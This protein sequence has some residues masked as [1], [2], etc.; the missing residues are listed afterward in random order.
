MCG[1]DNDNC[2]LH[3]S[4]Q[5]VAKSLVSRISGPHSDVAFLV[6]RLFCLFLTQ[7]DDTH[8]V[9]S[10]FLIPHIPH[11]S[12]MPCIV[13]V[14][15]GG[16]NPCQMSLWAGILPHKAMA[17]TMPTLRSY[18]QFMVRLLPPP[19]TN[20]LLKYRST[21]TFIHSGQRMMF[22]HSFSLE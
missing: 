14:Q 1:Q 2:R 20:S 5:S 22:C 7:R 16:L 9:D 6:T 12:I 19:Q 3:Y 10:N 18:C 21:P 8:I 13:S 17:F 4:I 11:K 15:C